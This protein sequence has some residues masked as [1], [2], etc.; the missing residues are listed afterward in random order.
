MS[1]RLK[2]AEEAWGGLWVVDAEDLP[3]FEDEE[4]GPITADGIRRVANRLVDGKAKGVDGWSPAELR[5]SSQTHTQGLADILNKI[6]NQEL[7]GRKRTLLSR[8]FRK[9][10]LDGC[11]KERVKQW[12]MQPNDGRFSAPETL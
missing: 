11:Q 3:K 4:M 6:E 1:E 12:A 10:S 2:V 9:A 5:A 8:S 7:A